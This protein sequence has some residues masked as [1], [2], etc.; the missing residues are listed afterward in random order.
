M[1]KGGIDMEYRKKP[2]V[3]EAWEFTMDSLKDVYSGVRRYQN[4]IKLVSQYGGEVL[5][6]EIKTLEGTMRAELGD[7]IIKDIQGELYPCKHDIFE[8]T[9]SLIRKETI[10]DKF[11]LETHMKNLIESVFGAPSDDEMIFSLFELIGVAQT[12]IDD[13]GENKK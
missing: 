10:A 8:A 9:Y 7:Y 11:D 12:M 4:D 1:I 5:Y 6:L 13:L 2:V 3:I